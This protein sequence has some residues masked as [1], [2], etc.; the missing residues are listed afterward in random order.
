MV[1]TNLELQLLF[2][3]LFNRTYTDQEFSNYSSLSSVNE[4]EDLL[5]ETIEYKILY[6]KF[7]GDL[8]FNEQS[9]MLTVTNLHPTHYNGLT[10]GNGKI[11]LTT[12]STHYGI[13]KTFITL[14]FE[15]TSSGEYI[16]NVVTS[17]DF[18]IVS[19]NAFDDTPQVTLTNQELRMKHGIFT[20]NYHLSLDST[21]PSSQD[22]AIKQD[23]RV[24]RQYP[25][26][27]LQTFTIENT[28]DTTINDLPFYHYI[29][30][31]D[32]IIN[33]KYSNNLINTNR[34]TQLH[35]F[36]A[37][38]TKKINYITNTFD[39]VSTSAYLFADQS[40]FK[41]NGYNI[42]TSKSRSG[43]NKFTIT[44]LASNQELQFSIITCIMSEKDNPYPSIETNKIILNIV[45]Y[46]TNQIIAQHFKEWSKLWESDIVIEQK[47]NVT[48]EQSKDITTF[49]RMLKF[50]LFNVYS[51]IREDVNVEINPLNLSAIDMDGN[52]FWNS[53]LWLIPILLF[54]KPKVAKTLLD[55]RFTQLETAKKIA[56]SNG[57]KG[58]KFAYKNDYVGYMDVYW[59]VM[60]P[61]HIYNTALIS[62]NTWNYYRVTKDMDWLITK[63]FKILK[64]NAN[65]FE[66]IIVR[67]T[68]NQDGVLRYAIRNVTALNDEKEAV[69]NN[70]LTN[71]FTIE[72]LRVAIEATYE[73]N[74]KLDQRWLTKYNGLLKSSN[75]TIPIFDNLDF[76]DD[77][78]LRNA[79]DIYIQNDLIEGNMV[80]SLYS[81]N[82]YDSNNLIG[83]EF[84]GYDGNSNTS[85]YHS[86]YK[87]NID[88][89][90]IYTFH[91]NSNLLDNPI[92]FLDIDNSNTTI[93]SNSASTSNH[94]NVTGYFNGELTI[95]G[96]E[97]FSY[98]NLHYNS[99]NDIV[100]GEM[101]ENFGYH[102]FTTDNNMVLN[103]LHNIIKIHDS[104]SST[105]NV[106][107][108]EP[109]IFLNPY[110]SK[111]F[112]TKYIKTPFATDVIKDN[113]TFYN[114]RTFPT[115]KNNSLNTLLESM[116]YNT[117]AQNEGVYYLKKN[118]AASSFH[119]SLLFNQ[120]STLE[121]WKSF[122]D[123]KLTLNST[124][125]NYNDLS[126]SSLFIFDL[127][128]TIGGLRIIGS[129]NDARFYTDDFGITNQT[130]YVMPHTWKNIKL[131]G[132][133]I[134]KY[135]YTIENTI[136]NSENE[137]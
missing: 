13:D 57:F 58:S 83:Y 68:D 24:L 67:D 125:G 14:K 124:N 10:L 6:T 76:S 106:Y 54:L 78:D 35:L 86:S 29:D 105:S 102:A 117:V 109:Y 65:F 79:T 97:L 122:Y 87:L 61:L 72:A 22:V 81:G 69:N 120:V 116:M 31:D 103:N 43:Y 77:F 90:K 92:S 75:E 99:R 82:I 52:I 134:N 95:S 133:G 46:T 94:N 131:Y 84:G 91:L 98:G 44:E 88:P 34:N 17:F 5:K 121:P 55:Y 25:Y 45:N 70:S 48:D 126:L 93:I 1:Y 26:C 64:N 137:L 40:N 118:A 42:L 66:N 20:T 100:F 19:F 32:D 36:S 50:A 63:G 27:V 16:N 71:Y 7:S 9:C 89:S 80:Y 96:G 21:N 11:A 114:S 135:T 53:E 112:F 33:V 123:N 104:S 136:Y 37:N 74:Y 56:I 12:N 107:H 28:T 15:Q 30:H 2:Y 115:Y 113:M 8:D 18:N 62:I 49:N 111:T 60:S 59:T 73:L 130:G 129:I 101:S 39:L 119:N 51:A 127:L 47:I 132:I 3:R 110:Y 128:T 108:P 38:G 23:I 85:N 41:H 4:L